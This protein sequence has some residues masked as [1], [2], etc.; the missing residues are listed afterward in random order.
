[1]VMTLNFVKATN[2][3]WKYKSNYSTTGYAI[4]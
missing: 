2:S 1:M 3:G 4:Q